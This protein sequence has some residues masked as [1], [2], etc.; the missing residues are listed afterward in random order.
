MFFICL[1]SSLFVDVFVLIFVIVIRSTWSYTFSLLLFHSTHTHTEKSSKIQAHFI[2]TLQVI[3]CTWMWWMVTTPTIHRTMA[4]NHLQQTKTRISKQAKKQKQNA[5]GHIH[6]DK[7]RYVVEAGCWCFHW[8]W[9]TKQTIEIDFDSI[10]IEFETKQMW[11]TTNH[12]NYEMILK[13]IMN[14]A[15]TITKIHCR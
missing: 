7:C 6:D 9:V 13:C 5:Y 10:S 14:N 15:Q 12:T 2:D 4:L 8:N 11:N 3:L 1:G